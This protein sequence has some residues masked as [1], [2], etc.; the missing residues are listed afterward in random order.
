MLS[1]QRNSA[2]KLI[3]ATAISSVLI[4]TLAACSGSTSSDASDSSDDVAAVVVTPESTSPFKGTVL[5]KPFNKPAVTLT[6]TKGKPFS[7]ANDTK[8]KITVVYVGFTHCPDVCPTTMADVAV[9]V[10]NLPEE[11]RDQ[12]E[13]VMVTSDPARDTTKVLGK[14]LGFFREGFIGLTGDYPDVAQAAHEMGVPISKPVKVRNG[15]WVVDHGAQV[16]LFGP[17]G[18]AREIFTSGFTSA[19]LTNDIELLAKGEQP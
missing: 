4:A 15:N 5:S 6:S 14:W 17:D 7:I 1:S 18:K 3:V 12:T 10:R 2:L 19:D 16:L 13:V 11:V 9:A 8:G